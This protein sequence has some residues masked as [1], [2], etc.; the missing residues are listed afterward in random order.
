VIEPESRRWIRLLLVLL[1]I[2]G[3]VLLVRDLARPTRDAVIE[4][5]E[6]FENVVEEASRR[7]DVDPDLVTAVIAVESKGDPAARSRAGALGLMQLMPPTGKEWA[8]RLGLG[9]VDEETLL[10][11]AL[12]VSIGTAYLRAQLDSFDEDLVLA[13]AAYN[14]GP[15]NVRKWVRMD[16]DVDSAE[17]LRRHGFPATRAYVENV[18][19]YLAHLRSKHHPVPKE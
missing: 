16:P 19:G 5:V 4:R 8:E 3:M 7:H 14:A 15:G 18:L 12:N 1:A 10:D 11:P 6:H 17:L 13:L 9:P 2:P